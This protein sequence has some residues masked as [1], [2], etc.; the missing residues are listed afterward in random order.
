[1][2]VECNNCNSK[3]DA[4]VLGSNDEYHPEQGGGCRFSLTKCPVCGST[5]LAGQ[6]YLQTGPDSSE[7]SIATRLWPEPDNYLHWT[8]PSEVRL[9]LDEARKCC[10]ARA[11]MACTVMCGRAIEAI[12]LEHTKEKSFAKGLKTLKDDGII[13]GRLFEWGDSLRLERNLGAHPTGTKTTHDD[14]RDVLDFAIAICEYVFVL[15]EKYNKYKERKDNAKKD[16][17]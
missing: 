1:M 12:C 16:K 13:D 14:A 3:V 4:E 15:S 10:K 6:D 8:I 2:I 5:L 17:T 11:F 7:W 9:A